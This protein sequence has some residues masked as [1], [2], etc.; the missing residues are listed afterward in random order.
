MIT[1]LLGEPDKLSTNMHY[2]R[3]PKVKLYLTSRVEEMEATPRFVELREKA[4]R[5]LTKAAKSA[6]ARRRRL[7]AAVL[8]RPY[9]LRVYPR[10]ELEA[11]AIAA[12]EEASAERGD[13]LTV[14]SSAGEIFIATL[15]VDF[16]LAHCSDF[17]REL[18]NVVG[19]NGADEARFMIY[20]EVFKRIMQI[21]P[22]LADECW[23]RRKEQREISEMRAIFSKSRKPA[24]AVPKTSQAC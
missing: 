14:R 16:L 7:L 8:A 10:A 6:D 9:L 22:H 23:R 24:G 13:F 17:E 20:G 12:F 2:L 19:K 1:T 4:A 3:G 21:Y 11:L 18:K 5:R 15:C